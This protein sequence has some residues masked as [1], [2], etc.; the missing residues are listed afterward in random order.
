MLILL[1]LSKVEYLRLDV[2]LLICLFGYLMLAERFLCVL[3]ERLCDLCVNK[4]N[5]LNQLLTSSLFKLQYKNTKKHLS[6]WQKFKN[7][8]LKIRVSL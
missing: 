6:T 4:R 2:Y 3:C 8:Y 7:I 1:N 5:D